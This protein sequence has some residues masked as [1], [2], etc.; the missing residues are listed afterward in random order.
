MAD[1]V[2]NVE[3]LR[4]NWGDQKVWQ[5]A[6]HPAV[7]SY[8][9]GAD[10]TVKARA[11]LQDIVGSCR[12]EH[13]KHIAMTGP[14]LAA[15]SRAV[16]ERIEQFERPEAASIEEP[17]EAQEDAEAMDDDDREFE[18][19]THVDPE[20][21]FNESLNALEAYLEFQVLRPTARG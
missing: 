18:E 5:R 21:L 19:D 17:A 4:K 16:E 3:K 8:G 10:L 14:L 12:A 7:D 20:V 1:D 6:T 15:V 2:F 9:T 11:L 13:P